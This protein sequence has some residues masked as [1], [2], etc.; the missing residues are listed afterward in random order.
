MIITSVERNKRN[1]EMLSVFVDE[2][3]AFSILEED[4]LRLCLYEKKEI[5]DDEI[6]SIKNNVTLR[7]A[8]SKAVKYLSYRLLSEAELFQKL[9]A[10]GYDED[11]I[12]SVISELKSMGYINDMI[13]AQKFVYERVKLKPKSKKMLRMELNNKGISD[14]V[15]ELVLEDLDFD[16]DVVIE[17][18]IRKKFGKY[19]MKEPKIVRKIYSFLMHRGFSLENIKSVLGRITT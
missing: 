15:I 5:C 3:Y 4:Y 6:E 12:C 17:R 19:D 18:L 11:V 9:Q 2:R 10:K 1:K 13:Y 8:K 16:E 14:D 7:S